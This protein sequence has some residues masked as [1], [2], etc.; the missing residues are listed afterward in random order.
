V[1]EANGGLAGLLARAESR[2][3]W[4]PDDTKS[5]ARFERVVIEGEPFILKYQDP[6]DDWLLRASGDPGRAYVR[7]WESGVLDRLPPEIDHAV[8]AADY[9][10]AV[11]R[12]L[13]RDVATSLLEPDAPFTARQH[14]RYMKHMAALHA[15][16][17]GWHDDIGL[18]SLERRYLLLSPQVAAAEEARG[19]SADVPRAMADGW[20]CL[21]EVSP[22]MAKVVL[23]LLDDPSRLVAA[24]AR[25]PHTLV[26]GDWK[27]A[28]LGSH[29]DGRTVLLDFGELPGEASPLADVGW[30]LALNAALL[31]E[32]KDDALE[33][34]RRALEESGVATSGWWDDA[35]ALELLGCMMQF[36]WEKALGGVGE[37]L[38]WW[39]NRVQRGSRRLDALTREASPSV[40]PELGDASRGP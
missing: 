9:D 37:E 29:P 3:P 22:A 8:V 31:P 30:Y 14:A 33:T 2:R 17:W 23:P 18:T 32:S 25:V 11:G 7:L 39:E 12:V 24:L 10:G 4:T 26:H 34:Y 40:P 15:A 21:P 35:V 16:F 27:A 6:R 19:T 1:T 38:K 13:L 20:R 36:G 28:N 5:G